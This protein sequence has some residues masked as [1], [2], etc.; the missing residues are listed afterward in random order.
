M[1]TN[2]KP[3]TMTRCDTLLQNFKVHRGK[4]FLGCVGEQVYYPLEGPALD[5]WLAVKP[6]PSVESLW[7]PLLVEALAW[8]EGAE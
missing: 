3:L 1:S 8:L 7:S 4:T 5:R 6:D 2:R